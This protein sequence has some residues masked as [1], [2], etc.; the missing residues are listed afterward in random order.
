M[1][2]AAVRDS[3]FDEWNVD[4]IFGIPGQSWEQAQADLRAA[5]AVHPTHI[6]LYDL[7]YTAHYA[8]RVAAESGPAARDA[9]AAFA[10][11]HYADAT[12][13]LESAG[14]GGTRC[15]TTRCPG[16]SAGT[17]WPTGGATTTWVSVRRR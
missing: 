7:T 1:A 16:T 5:A 10:E 9:A 4:L 11:E 17:T 13:L 2:L 12:A 3:G 14:I 15:R 6:S 8:A